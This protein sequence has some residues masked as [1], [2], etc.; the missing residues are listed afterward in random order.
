[1][2]TAR[3]HAGVLHWSKMRELVEKT[4]LELVGGGSECI[5]IGTEGGKVLKM[6]Y[7]VKSP[8]E[9]KGYF[10]RQRLM[11]ALFPENFPHFMAAGTV[12]NSEVG[13][14]VAGRVSP[15]D[16]KVKHSFNPVMAAISEL[17]LPIFIETDVFNFAFGKDGGEYYIDRM[18]ANGGDWNKEDIT[19]Y[20]RVRQMS[21]DRIRI[22]EMSIDRLKALGED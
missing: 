5:V 10:Y 13:V 18:E 16:G 22:V 1:M 4:D 3:E 7:R 17:K 14:T 9:M 20:M 12:K 2:A 8:E 6:D 11:E 15:G 19:K 21:D